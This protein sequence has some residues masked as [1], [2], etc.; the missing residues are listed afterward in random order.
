[1]QYKNAANT[2]CSR[3]H[4]CFTS[5]D[6]G[7]PKSSRV[8]ATITLIGFHAATHCN[9]PGSEFPI[10]NLP[11]GVFSGDGGAPRGGVAIGDQVLDLR[12]ALEAGLIGDEAAE[13]AAEPTL[14]RLMAMGRPASRALLT[15]L[16]LF[17]N[18]A[19]SS[20]SCSPRNRA[21]D[22]RVADIR[23]A[24][25]RVH[26]IVT[27]AVAFGRGERGLAERM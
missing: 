20:T 23:A 14:N 10:Q 6:R 5:G 26:R 11:L 22:L 25:G 18:P 13:A 3:G 19:V 2:G 4:V 12:A 21:S 24:L 8:A 7:F 9:A 15:A 27:G 17:A 16:S 1:M